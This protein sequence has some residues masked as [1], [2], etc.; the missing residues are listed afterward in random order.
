MKTSK[1]IVAYIDGWVD[2]IKTGDENMDNLRADLRLLKRIKEYALSDDT[3]IEVSK[4]DLNNLINR[5]FEE[6]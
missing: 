4:P 1:E 5:E 3:L 6:K 2:T